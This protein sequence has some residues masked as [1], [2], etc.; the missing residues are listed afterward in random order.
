LAWHLT[1][2]KLVAALNNQYAVVS[3]GGKCAVLDEHEAPDGKIEIAFSTPGD[4]HNFLANKVVPDPQDPRKNM[5][6]SKLWWSWP[7]RREYQGITFDPSTSASSIKGY[8]NLFRGLAYQPREGDW[9]LLRNHIFHVIAN[10]NEQLFDYVMAWMATIV[11]RLGV[12]R[13]PTSL[14]LRG[15]QGTGKGTLANAFGSLFGQHYVPMSNPEHVMG[16]FNGHLKACLLAYLDEIFWT[17]DRKAEGVI[18]HMVSEP[19]LLIEHKGKDVIRIPN[20]MSLIFSSNHS[21]IVPAGVDERRFVVLDVSEARRCNT[22]YFGAIHAQLKDGGR[23]AFLYDLLHR[24][25]TN[26]DL[27]KYDRTLAL[28]EQIVANLPS[29]L[30]FWH[31]LLATGLLLEDD[32]HWGPVV[33]SHLFYKSY[34]KYMK[35]REFKHPL[36]PSQFGME[37]R[38]LCK[39]IRVTRPR[40]NNAARDRMW[41]FPSLS[42]CRRQFENRV[43]MPVSWEF[44]D[45]KGL[46]Y[47]K[48]E[49]VAAA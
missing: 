19:Y 11:Q 38:K 37:M 49:D 32:V 3:L 39:P 9:S 30:A 8:Y 47:E 42:E 10:G 43:R 28:F 2:K 1:T 48:G 21:W 25:I 29:I 46:G 26:V 23:E 41:E 6:I 7:G 18:K 45:P 12:D 15:G 24:D 22:D 27:T 16:R 5:S 31:D 44:D 20:H 17:E 4:F 34:L 36:G 14:V 33:P 13:P 40:Q 35:Q